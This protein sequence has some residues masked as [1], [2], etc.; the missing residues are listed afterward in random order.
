MTVLELIND[1]QKLDRAHL[2]VF[3][4]VSNPYGRDQ[5]VPVLGVIDESG[6]Q[7]VI[8]IPEMSPC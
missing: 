1:L 7:A 6:R 5:Y 3:V 4:I 8:D 2:E